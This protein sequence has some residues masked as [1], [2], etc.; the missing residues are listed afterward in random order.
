VR[1][2]KAEP[3]DIEI[4]AKPTDEQVFGYLNS[5]DRAMREFVAA[6]T[7]QLG[8]PFEQRKKDPKTGEEK[9]IICK[10]PFSEKYYRVRYKGA[11]VDV[12]VCTPPASWGV[13]LLLRTGDGGH[14]IWIVTKGYPRGIYFRQGRL[15]RHLDLKDRYISEAEW[16]ARDYACDAGSCKWVVVPTP[17]EIDVFRAL[18]LDYVK[19]EDRVKWEPATPKD[20]EEALA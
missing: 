13:Q 6:G 2:Q 19:P 9:V 16:K 15:V 7:I 18:L 4:V 8:D 12:F 3:H 10:A 5:V 20:W 14:N 1:R 17:E 11:K